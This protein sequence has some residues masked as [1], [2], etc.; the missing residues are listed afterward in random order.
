MV[1]HHVTKMIY[2]LYKT[3]FNKM[4]KRLK[5]NTFFKFKHYYMGLY[6][7]LFNYVLTFIGKKT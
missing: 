7:N 5:F 6:L 4:Y 1:K 2:I 3:V